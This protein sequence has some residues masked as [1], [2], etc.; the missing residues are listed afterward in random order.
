MI[1]QTHA[2]D[3]ENGV[4]FFIMGVGLNNHNTFKFEA[5]GTTSRI[6]NI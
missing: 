1:V 2:H 6:K 5:F 4:F 3:K